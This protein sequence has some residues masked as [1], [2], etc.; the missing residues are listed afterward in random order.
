M[1]H[2]LMALMPAGSSVT[3]QRL[4]NQWLVDRMDCIG[5]EEIPEYYMD[6]WKTLDPM[7]LPFG[8]IHEWHQYWREYQSINQQEV[9]PAE[10]PQ[11]EASNAYGSEA[12]DITALLGWLEIDALDRFKEVVACI[13]DD[14]QK[15]L[16]AINLS[17][18]SVDPI[19]CRRLPE[20][21]HLHTS[22]TIL[23]DGNPSKVKRLRTILRLLH[24][25][26]QGGNAEMF[27]RIEESFNSYAQQ[28]K[29]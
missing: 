27:M 9:S 1:L 11:G 22:I 23:T 4:F 7:Q 13:V 17:I 16:V 14:N 24:H 2:E 12:I 8:F 29:V 26:D 6:A 21:D 18:D 19:P 25:P 10:L 15:T 28:R 5:Y 20:L 3:K